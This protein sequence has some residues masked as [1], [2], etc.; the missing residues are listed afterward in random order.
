LG[1]S[2]FADG[3]GVGDYQ[4]QL[5]R[6]EIKTKSQIKINSY[7]KAQRRKFNLRIELK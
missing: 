2:D 7:Q 3:G 1:V 4:F 5:S 6:R